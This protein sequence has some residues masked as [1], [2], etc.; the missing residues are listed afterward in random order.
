MNHVTNDTI[1]KLAQLSALHLEESEVELLAAQLS[2]ILEYVEQIADA[3]VSRFSPVRLTNQNIFREDVSE[4]KSTTDLLTQAPEK[5]DTY[6]VV[7][8]ILEQNK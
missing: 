8:Q 5:H 2:T 6:F 3:D 4:Q 1:K 7:P